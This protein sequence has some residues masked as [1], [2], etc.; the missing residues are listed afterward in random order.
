VALMLGFSVCPIL[1]FTRRKLARVVA[2]VVVL[3]VGAIFGSQALKHGKQAE[4]S[5]PVQGIVTPVTKY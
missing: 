3:A 4:Q 1:H 5:K 2:A